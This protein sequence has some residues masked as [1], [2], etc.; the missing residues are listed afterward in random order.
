MRAEL[1]GIPQLHQYCSSVPAQAQFDTIS[2]FIRTK[3]PSELNS[4][5]LW[6]LPAFDDADE[7]KAASIRLLLENA[8]RQLHKVSQIGPLNISTCT[9]TR[10][11][12][13]SFLGEL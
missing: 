12:D 2:S 6:T 13:S 10:N 8:E 4:L 9:L 1:S 5:G 3:V 11:S 7:L